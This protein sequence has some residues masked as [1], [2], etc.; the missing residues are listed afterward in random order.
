MFIAFDK[1]VLSA[2]VNTFFAVLTK[3]QCQEGMFLQA[4]HAKPYTSKSHKCLTGV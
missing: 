3:M 1:K 2:Q 4:L